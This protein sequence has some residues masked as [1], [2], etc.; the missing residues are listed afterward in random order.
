MIK[1]FCIETDIRPE[2]DWLIPRDYSDEPLRVLWTPTQ[3]D[4]QACREA[5]IRLTGGG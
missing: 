4:R 2:F 1:F 3:I 5:T